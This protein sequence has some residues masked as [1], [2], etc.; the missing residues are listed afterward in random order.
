[1]LTHNDSPLPF[2]RLLQ[3]EER[4]QANVA[5]VKLELEAQMSDR[6][7]ALETKVDR[8]EA[9]LKRDDKSR[10]EDKEFMVSMS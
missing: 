7:Q 6:F 1:M 3:V 8:C 10:T 5:N 2:A 9:F 4:I